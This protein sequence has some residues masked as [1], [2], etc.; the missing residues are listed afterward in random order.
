MGQKIANMSANILAR[1]FKIPMTDY[2][3]IDISLDRHVI[4]VFKRTGL[5]RKDAKNEEIIYRA[6]EIKPEYP[7]VLDL[8]CFNIGQNWC[9]SN[10]N[11]IKCNECLLGEYCHRIIN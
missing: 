7:G 9:K 5:V 2:H 10:V 4:R 6:R 8:P 3:S 11:E 1:D